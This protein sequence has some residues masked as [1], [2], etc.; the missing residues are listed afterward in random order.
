MQ[1]VSMN[2][3]SDSCCHVASTAPIVGESEEYR[4]V[5]KRLASRKLYRLSPDI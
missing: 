5:V 1:V 3:K 2:C 4:Y